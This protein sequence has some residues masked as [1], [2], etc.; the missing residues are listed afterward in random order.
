MNY[1][2]R[3]MKVTANTNKMAVA[4]GAGELILSMERPGGILDD[5]TALSKPQAV[6]I[7]K[8]II[9][10]LN[11][12]DSKVG[13]KDLDTIILALDNIY[14]EWEEKEL[15]LFSVGVDVYDYDP[16][17][18]IGGEIYIK[19]RTEKD[20]VKIAGQMHRDE[21]MELGTIE[22]LNDWVEIGIERFATEVPTNQA[23]GKIVTKKVV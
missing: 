2:D 15:K 4:D 12:S 20:A 5:L 22:G 21:L 3:K 7:I 23:R 9:P 11:K 6:E 18:E 19:A 1:T 17:G 8:E 14:K 16:P 13:T 10:H